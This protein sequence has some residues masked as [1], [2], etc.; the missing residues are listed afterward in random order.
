MKVLVFGSRGYLGRL[1]LSAYPGAIASTVDI[2]D[3]AAV[4]AELDTHKPEVVINAAGK[5]GRPNIDWCEDHKLETLHANVTGPL[6]L[7]EE[8]GQRGIYWVHFGSGC[9]Y[10]GDNGGRGFTEE[11]KPNY[12]GSFYSRTKIWSDQILKEFPLLNLRLR[13]PFDGTTDDRNLIT[14]IRKYSRVLIEQNSLTYVPDFLAAAK[15]LIEEKATG[16]F[17]IVNPGSI[18]PFEIM[19]LYRELVDPNHQ[20]ESLDVKA[21]KEVAKTG[22]SNCILSGEKLR[23]RGIELRPVQEVIREAMFTLKGNLRIA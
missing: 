11:D 19:T 9:I 12:F 7:L 1:F 2:A 4:A 13:M 18:S 5:T 16:T 22:R 10:E 8:C 17:N 3:P 15:Q 21:L 6:V 23:S 14:K 20:F